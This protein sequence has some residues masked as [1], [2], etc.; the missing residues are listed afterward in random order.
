MRRPEV[1]PEEMGVFLQEVDDHLQLLDE[2]IVRLEK[3]ASNADLL[4]E[5]FRAAH[6]L[7]GSSGMMGV[8][9]M[10]DLTH[11]MEDVLDR[12]RKGSLAVTP[13]LV[14]VLLQS[15]DVLKAMRRCL[16]SEEE[17]SPRIEPLVAALGG[18]GDEGNGNAPAE[19]AEHPPLE[20]VLASDPA[21]IAEL[22]TAEEDGRGPFRV[23]AAVD[24]GADLPSVRLL[25]LLT[26]LSTV[27]KV[28][29]SVPSQREI[30]EGETGFEL[31]AVIVTEKPKEELDGSL[32]SLPDIASLSIEPWAPQALVKPGPNAGDG[33][34]PGRIEWT[35]RKTDTD[36][37]IRMDVSRLDS[38]VDMVGELVIDR[39]RI[40]QIVTSLQS[41][42]GHDDLMSALAETS[43]HIVKVV[44]ELNESMMQARMMPIGRLFGGFARLVRDLAR[45]TAKN[46]NFVLGGEDTEIDTSVIEKIKDPLVQLIRNAVD[47]GIEPPDMRLERGKR[48]SGLIRLS[49]RHEHGYI[50]ITVTDDGEGI[51]PRHVR[52]SCVEKGIIS[53]KEAKHLTDAESLDLIFT[54][55]ASTAPGTTEVSGRGV[56]LD[57]VKREVK[58]LNGVIEID[59]SSGAGTTFALRLP[60]TLA[61]FQGLLVESA[62]TLY[63]IPLSHVQEI[64]SPEPGSIRAVMGKRILTLR[65]GRHATAQSP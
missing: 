15:L 14:D 27:A 32:D 59:T 2:A 55:G 20:Q 50:V 33:A 1:T 57:V 41:R 24:S 12:L 26:K 19:P 6:T 10:A 13:E 40:Q 34:E 30:E 28:I 58:A 49:A 52:E 25:Q 48:E 65:G 62:G 35:R 9:E 7:K 46:V 63:A 29:C 17:E 51:N 22:R 18:I 42:Y 3:E 16:V 8:R 11:A 23:V 64:A 47:H 4:Q 21:A 39:N 38:L 54:A 31:D 36:Q 43:A 53:A 61:T 37:T 56:G 5:I 45:S 60:L 44:D